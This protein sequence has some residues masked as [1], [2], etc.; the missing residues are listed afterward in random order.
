MSCTFEDMFIHGDMGRY[1]G[2]QATSDAAIRLRE[3]RDGRCRRRGYVSIV[4]PPCCELSSWRPRQCT[5]QGPQLLPLPLRHDI[6][7]PTNT[8]LRPSA[9][10]M[11]VDFAVLLYPPAMEYTY[12]Y[13]GSIECC[14]VDAQ[15]SWKLKRI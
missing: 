5:V 10:M 1:L 6:H 8:K 7:K 3:R 12:E 2:L 4:P 13:T 15:A 11:F 14:L 9:S